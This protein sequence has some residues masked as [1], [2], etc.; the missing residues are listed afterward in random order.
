M[1]ID[2]ELSRRTCDYYKITNIPFTIL[3]QLRQVCK[4]KS[5]RKCCE[6]SFGN[7]DAKQNRTGNCGNFNNSKV[8]ME[9][10]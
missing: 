1:T 9:L 2:W 3:R 6:R 8:R 4:L 10:E 7:D 5:L